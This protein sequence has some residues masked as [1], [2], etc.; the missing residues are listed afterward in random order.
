MIYPL[1]YVTSAL[2]LG[3]S[4]APYLMPTRIHHINMERDISRDEYCISN[5]LDAFFNDIWLRR[6]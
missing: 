3:F 2:D 1:G 4:A 6:C 5:T